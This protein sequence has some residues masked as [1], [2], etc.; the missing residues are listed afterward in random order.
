MVIFEKLKVGRSDSLSIKLKL[1][2]QIRLS[3][4]VVCNLLK[5][6]DKALSAPNLHCGRRRSDSMTAAR[7]FSFFDAKLSKLH[8][9][10]NTHSV[11]GIDY[12]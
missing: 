7:N 3:V 10:Y 12:S 1:Q 4:S 8:D 9:K 5:R 2:I 11:S 6:A